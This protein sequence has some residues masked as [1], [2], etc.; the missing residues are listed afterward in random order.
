[1]DIN[2]EKLLENP[3]EIDKISVIKSDYS[4]FKSN[5]DFVYNT[6][7]SNGEV[8]FIDNRAYVIFERNPQIL[9]LLSKK[10]GFNKED[11]YFKDVKI[12]ICGKSNK[13]ISGFFKRLLE[14]IK[15]YT[16]WLTVILL[17]YIVVF[18]T[19]NTLT[20][21]ENLNNIFIDITSIFISM[22]FI[23]STMFY[24]NDSLDKEAQNGKI[25]EIFVIDKYIFVLA[26]LALILTMVSNGLI[27]YQICN[28]DDIKLIIEIIKEKF[29]W[30]YWFLK[31]G[32]AKTLTGIAI[33]FIFICY[34]SIIDYYLEKIKLQVI[35]RQINKIR[36]KF[37]DK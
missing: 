19:S 21:I 20:G 35:N 34:R 37:R 9:V 16:K 14:D 15:G 2:L 30:L 26:M 1:M 22:L 27:N 11:F 31:E 3:S 7:G 17:I 12:E 24:S 10:D 5:M 6:L 29:N 28:H 4:L 32:C 13:Y 8:F 25:Q 36:A 18:A 23:F 33:V